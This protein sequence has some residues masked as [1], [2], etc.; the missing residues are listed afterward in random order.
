MTYAEMMAA[1]FGEHRLLHDAAAKAAHHFARQLDEWCA[2]A[3]EY[4]PAGSEEDA[5]SAD[6]M[7]VIMSWLRTV[8]MERARIGGYY[9]SADWE[10]EGS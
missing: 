10:E 5:G 1:W 6:P 4:L 2:T 9:S 7:A 3:Y 8:A